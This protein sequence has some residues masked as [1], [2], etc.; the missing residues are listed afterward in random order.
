MHDRHLKDLELRLRA[1]DE[2]RERFL[3]HRH[4]HLVFQGADARVGPHASQEHDDGAGVIPT[5]AVHDG[6]HVDAGP[7]DGD[8]VRPPLTG[9]ITATSSPSCNTTSGEA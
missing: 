5:D 3:G 8:H 7:L 2:R 9:G 4:V 6:R 1:L